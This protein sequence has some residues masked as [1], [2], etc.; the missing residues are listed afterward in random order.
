MKVDYENLHPNSFID[1]KFITTDS[2]M[3]DRFFYNLIS[4]GKF[5]GPVKL[6]RASRWIYADYTKWKKQQ[7]ALSRSSSPHLPG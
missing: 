5:P 1:M 3:T 7:I 2:K 4:C 6:G